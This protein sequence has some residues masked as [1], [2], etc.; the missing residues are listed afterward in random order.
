MAFAYINRQDVS[1]IFH[2]THARMRAI[3]AQVDLAAPTYTPPL[4]CVDDVDPSIFTPQTWDGLFVEWTYKFF[5]YKQTK[6][7]DWHVRSMARLRSQIDAQV[8]SQTRRDQLIEDV[9]YLADTGRYL[10][11]GAFTFDF[12]YST[13]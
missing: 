12:T 7:M 2:A 8:S 11:V 4:F 6:M 10:N 5:A 1:Q 3:L 13:W 9:D